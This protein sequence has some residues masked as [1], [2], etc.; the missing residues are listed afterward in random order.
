MSNLYKVKF[1]LTLDKVGAV[2]FPLGTTHNGARERST[3]EGQEITQSAKWLCYL[4]IFDVYERL[5][6]FEKV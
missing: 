1:K 5:F 3:T 6:S 4:F 2:L